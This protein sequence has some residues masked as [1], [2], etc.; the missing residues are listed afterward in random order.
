MSC[1]RRGHVRANHPP[2]IATR[3]RGRRGG[4]GGESSVDAAHLRGS[5]W[6]ATIPLLYLLLTALGLRRVPSAIGVI[7]ALASPMFLVYGSMLDTLQIAL[8]FAVA[9]LVVRARADVERR[10]VRP[11]ISFFA[12]AVLLVMGSWEGAC[13][14]CGIFVVIDTYRGWRDGR[15][16]R[17]SQT[18]AG[19]LV[20]LV[21]VAAWFWWVAGSFAPVFEQARMRSGSGAAA[22]GWSTFLDFQGIYL[23][24]LIGPVVLVAGMAGL[25]LVLRGKS[26][27]PT[28]L[29]IVAVVLAYPVLLRDGASNHDYLELLD[30]DPVGAWRGLHGAVPLVLGSAA[31]RLRAARAR[32]GFDRLR[33]LLRRRR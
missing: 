6:L 23:G 2:L 17:P 27:R 10:P 3:Y 33:D 31:V 5:Y 30:R 11:W 25:V 13:S 18:T 16:M 1:R 24:A 7:I 26:V 9:F 4:A 20:G 29:A 21:L 32:G 19:F 12:V 14:L 28:V 15:R 22:I 8:P